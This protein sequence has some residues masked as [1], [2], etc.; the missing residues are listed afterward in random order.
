MQTVALIM[1]RRAVAQTLMQALQEKSGFQV[2]YEPDYAGADVAIRSRGAGV[3]LIEVAESGEFDIVYC[4]GLCAWLRV[5]TPAC[6]LILM[7]SEQDKACIGQVVAAKKDGRIDEFVFY[8]TSE[9]YL[10][11]KLISMYF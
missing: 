3:A 10:A 2:C 1:R 9:E 5:E 7:C 8:D 4:L 6:K 11:T